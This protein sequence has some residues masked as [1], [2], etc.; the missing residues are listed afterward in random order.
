MA[1]LLVLHSGLSVPRDGVQMWRCRGKCLDLLRVEG[2]SEV[3]FSNSWL[4]VCWWSGRERGKALEN[5][6]VEWVVRGLE[7]GSR[8]GKI[9]GGGRNTRSHG[10][11]AN[12]LI[13]GSGRTHC[14]VRQNSKRRP[15]QHAVR[16]QTPAWQAYL[17][18]TKKA[19]RGYP[20][21]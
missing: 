1:V 10:E 6:A 11:M 21:W 8:V 12:P 4:E 17:C 16:N 14:A 2:L 13:T 19:D 18:E 3:A 20:R 15:F 5:G 9:W 7:E